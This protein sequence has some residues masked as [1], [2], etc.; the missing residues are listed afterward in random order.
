MR[1]SFLGPQAFWMSPAALSATVR[2]KAK[3]KTLSKGR[4]KNKTHCSLTGCFPCF[5]PVGITCT[6]LA[7]QPSVLWDKK[8][9]FSF[10]SSNWSAASASAP[11]LGHCYS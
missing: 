11:P 3:N 2:R 4:G 7:K 9:L 6:P 8:L 10:P 5:A 1:E